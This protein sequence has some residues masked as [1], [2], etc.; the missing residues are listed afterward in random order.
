MGIKNHPDVWDVVSDSS[1]FYKYKIASSASCKDGTH[2]HG[3]Q[4]F[5][6]L[7]PMPVL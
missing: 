1:N 4:Y 5:I 3:W 7:F 6:L 2:L